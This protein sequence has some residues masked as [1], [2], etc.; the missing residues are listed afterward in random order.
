MAFK[1]VQ[2]LEADVTI[3]LGGRNKKTGKDNPKSVEGYYL[4]KREVASAKSRNGK[5][6]IYYFQTSKGNVGV[7]GKTDLDRKMGS[8]T[9]GNMTRI[10]Q[11]GTRPTPNGDMYTYKVEQDTENSIEVSLLEASVG[12]SAGG[13]SDDNDEVEGY[14][15]DY[16]STSDEDESEETS[17]GATGTTGTSGLAASARSTRIQELLANGKGKR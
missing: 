1:E 15:G 17:Y 10:T 9:P 14:A 3:A 11:S 7:W 6:S 2:S 4:G 8:V 5:A 12:A 13:S 16:N